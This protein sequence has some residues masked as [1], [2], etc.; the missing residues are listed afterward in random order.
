M[1][2]DDAP[3]RECYPPNSRAGPLYGWVTIRREPFLNRNPAPCARPTAFGAD[4]KCPE[5]TLTTSVSRTDQ[6]FKSSLRNT[7]KS[8]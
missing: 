3:L 8:I 6:W 7:R 4:F 2:I 5:R 1:A